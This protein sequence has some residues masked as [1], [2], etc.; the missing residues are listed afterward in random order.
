VKRPDHRTEFFRML[1]IM[2][3]IQQT[4]DPA[5]THVSGLPP[6][7][8]NPTVASKEQDVCPA[9]FV[10]EAQCLENEPQ[11]M[12]QHTGNPPMANGIQ[13]ALETSRYENRRMKNPTVVNG[14]CVNLEGFF[15]FNR[16]CAGSIPARICCQRTPA[17]AAPSRS[18]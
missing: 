4:N 17:A 13:L 12:S 14:T 3:A 2:M 8:G 11:K 16:S 5:K 6:L 1:T 10:A 15:L 7:R 18:R 9:C